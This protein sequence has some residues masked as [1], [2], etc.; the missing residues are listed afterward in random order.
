VDLAQ[1]PDAPRQSRL[2]YGWIMLPITTLGLICSAPGQSFG[3]QPFKEL[4]S[5]SLNLSRS[6]VSGAYMVGTL[7][8]ALPMTYIGHC[9]DRFGA[10]RTLMVIVTLLA[11]ACVVISQA[12]G[13]ITLLIGFLLLRTFGQ[14]SLTLLNFNTM[15]MWFHRRLGLVN[16]LMSMGLA[17]AIAIVPTLNLTLIDTLGWRGAYLA[18]GGGVWLLMFPLLLFVFRNR[19]EDLNQRPDGDP[20]PG[21]DEPQPAAEVSLTLRQAMRHRA[22]WITLASVGFWAMSNTGLVICMASV[23]ETR[24]LSLTEASA[25]AATCMLAF[26]ITLAAMQLPA[27]YL[28]DRL[29]TNFLLSGSTLCMA[30]VFTLFYASRGHALIYG[31]G[32]FQGLAQA[33]LMAVNATLWVRYFGRSHL[34]KIKGT[35][36]TTMVAASAT[37]PLLVDGSFDLI[38]SYKPMLL[39]FAT[40]PFALAVAALFATPPVLEGPR[41]PASGLDEEQPSLEPETAVEEAT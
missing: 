26:G 38:G 2:F 7:I 32:L 12:Q 22:Y 14:G 6:E 37:G 25:A 3:V 10:R 24:G 8:A 30:G 9:M 33:L 17:G 41:D 35:M 36:T 15:A 39:A 40:L 27:G 21:D 20:M 13:V 23:F 28:V 19:P 34:G 31:I 29:P 18:L 1:Q 5:A 4:F 16:A 11:L